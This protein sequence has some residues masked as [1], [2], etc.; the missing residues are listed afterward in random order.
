MRHVR[1]VMRMKSAGM[2]SREIARRVG[3]APSTV[4][5][6]IRRFEASGLSWPLPDDVTDAV[7]ESQLFAKAGGGTRRARRRQAE[8]DWA[9]VYRE[10]RRKHVMLSIP[11][12]EYIAAK[13]AAIAIRASGSSTVPGRHAAG[14]KL[15]VDYAGDGVPVVIDRLSGERRAAQIFVAVLGASSFTYA[16]A[17][18]TQYLADRISGHVGAFE[19]GPT[20]LVPDSTKSRSSRPVSTIRRSTAA[21]PTWR[22]VTAPPFCRLGCGGHGTR[23]RS[24]RRSSW[25]ERWPLGRLRHHTFHSLAE[26]NAAIADLLTRLNEEQPI[27]RLGVTRRKLLEEVDRPAL[28][29]LPESSYVFAKW[30]ICRV[31][32]DYHVE[33]EAHYYSVPHRFVRAEVEVRFTACT[34]DIFHKSERTAAHQ[35]MSGNHK[36]TTVPEH[37]ASSHRRYAG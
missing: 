27:R 16:Q 19:G 4:R 25:V 13:P 5:L 30:G 26:V 10:L 29:A 28:K 33:V 2:L 36:H 7:L 15:I 20:L 17:S 37:M 12:E 9:A 3:A 14:D 1:D 23:R 18:W 35:H 6:T 8:P 24:S 31:S 21:T 22:R 32:V 34:V 11:W